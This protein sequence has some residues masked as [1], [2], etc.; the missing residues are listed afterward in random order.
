M[1]SYSIGSTCLKVDELFISARQLF[2]FCIVFHAMHAQETTPGPAGASVPPCTQGLYKLRI[3]SK[4]PD[5]PHMWH[6]FRVNLK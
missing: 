3:V 1:P 5:D 6:A 2:L 4:H